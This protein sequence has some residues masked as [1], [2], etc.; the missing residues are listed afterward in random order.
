MIG[1]L[2]E[3]GITGQVERA[4]LGRIGRED[5]CK[6]VTFKQVSED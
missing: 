3:W 2:M 6:E 5:F 4:T 1:R